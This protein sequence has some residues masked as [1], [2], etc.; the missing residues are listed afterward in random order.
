M[1]RLSVSLIRRFSNLS[2]AD[3][4]ALGSGILLFLAFVFVPWPW[5]TSGEVSLTALASWSFTQAASE[6]GMPVLLFI[7]DFIFLSALLALTWRLFGFTSRPMVSGRYWWVAPVVVLAVSLGVLV[8]ALVNSYANAVDVLFYVAMAAASAAILIGRERLN[9][10][11]QQYAS[12]LVLL[13]AF[14]AL[15]CWTF[16]IRQNFIAILFITVTLLAGGALQLRRELLPS[17]YRRPVLI[18]SLYA[19][20]AVLAYYGVLFEQQVVPSLLFVAIAAVSGLLL[21]MWCASTTHYKQLASDLQ[22]FVGL[23]V[24]TCYA[25]HFIQVLQIDNA[26]T[27]I[28]MQGPGFWLILVAAVGYVAQAFVPRATTIAARGTASPLIPLLGIVLANV[29]LLRALYNIGLGEYGLETFVRQMFF[30]GAQGSIYALIALGYTLVY[31]ILFMINFAHGEVFTAGAYLGFFAITAMAD[32]GFLY[33][34]TFFALLI[35]FVVAIATSVIVAIGLERIAYRPLRTAPRLVPLITAIGASIFLQ[36]AFKTLFGTA[37]KVYP[38]LN[39]YVF[40][41]LFSDLECSVVDGVEICRGLDLINGRYRMQVDFLGIEVIFR[42]IF[43]LIFVVAIVMMIGLWFYVQRTKQGKAMRAVA[44]DKTT[45]SLMGINVDNVIVTTFVLGAALAGVAA[46]LFALYN[47]QV[48]P[49]MGFLPGLKAFTAAVL[50]GIGNIPGAALGGFVLGFTESVAPSLLDIHNQL[51]DVL[52]FGILV[53][54]LIFRP[55]GI[56]GEVLTE[57]KA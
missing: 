33:A 51:K 13:T 38:R 18:L 9:A 25:I 54:V 55:S 20:F 27:L 48:T 43:V 10:N 23:S 21:A 22:L 26:S 53:L 57:T 28:G 7:I 32:S 31:G 56:L 46:V 15:G 14:A 39:F 52:A 4:V 3:Y 42:P 12:G 37:T 17:Q 34:N 1:R 49:R 16:L 50:G 40:P 6:N 11:F 35:V 5:A 24:L 47:S 41:Q 30:G 44:E 2:P 36:E 19:G 8:A 29:I 45:A